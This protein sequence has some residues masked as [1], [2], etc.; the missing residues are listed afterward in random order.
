MFAVPDSSASAHSRGVPSADRSS[1][2]SPPVPSSTTGLPAGAPSSSWAKAL[3]ARGRTR[4]ATSTTASSAD[5]KSTRLNSSHVAISYAVFCLKKKKRRMIAHDLDK[6]KIT[7]VQ[8]HDKRLNLSILEVSPLDA[9]HL[10]TK[11]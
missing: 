7:L 2:R 8:N 9:R 11:Y 5:R 10:T 3:P 1:Q 6:N 4:A